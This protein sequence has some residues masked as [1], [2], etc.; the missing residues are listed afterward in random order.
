MAINSEGRLENIRKLKGAIISVIAFYDLFDFS[1]TALEVW[2]FLG[3]KADF[4][5][6]FFFLE[7]GEPKDAIF[8][9]NGFYF[10]KGREDLTGI[11]Q[12]RYNISNQK[13][14]KALRAAKIFRIIPW[15]KMIAVGNIIA[16][17][18][19]LTSL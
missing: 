7:N 14:V 16:P 5:E 6:V 15:I 8:S 18:A 19:I 17:K 13:I 10:L 9:D 3:T 2:S 1:P 4:D 11:R 12:Q